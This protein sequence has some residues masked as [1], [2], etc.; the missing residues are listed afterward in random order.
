MVS[1]AKAP[2]FWYYPNHD[3][4]EVLVLPVHQ[5]NPRSFE[6]TDGI[7][8]DSDESFEYRFENNNEDARSDISTQWIF[9]EFS[10]G[11]IPHAQVTGIY[12]QRMGSNNAVIPWTMM[13]PFRQI[14][15]CPYMPE[16]FPHLRTS[17][18]NRS[19][20]AGEVVVTLPGPYHQ[21]FTLGYTKAE[22]MNYADEKWAPSKLLWCDSS[23][24]EYP[25]DR[26]DR[27]ILGNTNRIQ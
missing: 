15:T 10:D 26:Q 21:G 3:D 8:V 24:P 11:E 20:K 5:P 9:A 6:R 27:P 17:G 7:F 19:Q 25:I 18:K 23:Y 12:R 1:V 22:A 4:G 13:L 14:R 16:Y 2:Y